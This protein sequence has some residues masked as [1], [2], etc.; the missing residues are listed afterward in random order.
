MVITVHPDA[1]SSRRA[2][3]YPELPPIV[4]GRLSARRGRGDNGRDMSLI[5]T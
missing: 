4:A 5:G 2:Y 3:R 1:L